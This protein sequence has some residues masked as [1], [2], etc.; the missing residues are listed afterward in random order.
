MMTNFEEERDSL[1]LPLPLALSGTGSGSAIGI[2]SAA[3]TGTATASG[4]V[5]NLTIAG[6]PLVGVASGTATGSG[7]LVSR[8]QAATSRTRG[9]ALSMRGAAGQPR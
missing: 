9:H 6:R 7:R 2:G 1:T 8:D 5:D 4:S 3:A